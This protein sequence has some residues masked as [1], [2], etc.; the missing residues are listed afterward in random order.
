MQPVPESNLV[1]RTPA[2]GLS[3]TEVLAR[4]KQYGENSLP[5]EKSTPAWTILLNQV[6]SPLVY[7]ILVAAVVSLFAKEFS[8]F[9]I[10]MA[11]VVIDVI[12]G[13]IQEYQAQ[14]TYTAL[15]GLL[16]P[17]TTVFRDGERCEVEVW[18]LVPGDLVLLNAGE[19]V[20]G[21][22]VILEGIKLALD[23]AILTGESEAV[24]KTPDEQVYMGTTVL[25]GRGQMQINQTGPATELGKIATSLQEHVEEDTPLQKRLKSFSKT[26]T[27]IVA[28]FTLAIL[29]TG[30]IMGGGF[31]DM[32]RTSII[33]AIA[34]VPEGLLIAVTVILVLGM[35]KILKRNGLVKRLLAVET[36]GSVTVICTDK[37]GTLTEGRMRVSTSEILDQ[38]RALQTMVLCNDL[39]GPV[40][41]AMWEQAR[42]I[43]GDDPQKMVDGSQRLEEELFTSE[44]KYMI[45]AITGNIFKGESYNFLKGAPEIVLGMCNLSPEEEAR[46]RLKVDQW[47]GEGLR[48][49]G[50]AYRQLGKL[51]DYS[52]YSWVGLVGM[53][54]PVRKGVVESVEVAQKAGIQVKMITG[55]YLK[56]AEHIARSI[57]IMKEGEQSLEG[58]AVAA[59]SEK[60]LQEHVRNT[61]V[62]ARIRPQDKLRIIKALQ[63]NG[64]ITSMI[65]DG[66]NDAPALQRSNI[67]VVVGS[68]TDVAKETADVILLDNNFATIVAAIEEG[69]IIFQN[70]R[71]VVAYTLSNSFAEV[72]TI[73]IAMILGWPAPLIVAQILWIHLICDG[74]SDIVLGFEPKEPGIMDEKP[75]SLKEPILSHLGL[76]LIGIISVSS[77]TAVL[78]LFHHLYTAHG[79]AVEGRSIVFASFAVNSMVYIFAYRSMRQPL[80]RMNKL[81]VNMPLVWAVVTGLGMAILPFLIPG[82]RSLLGLVP[83]TLAE[84]MEVVGIALGL[85]A[86]VEVGKWISNK[87]HAND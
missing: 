27:W 39:E 1:Q 45:T 76:S 16:K 42:K 66:V 58:P 19:K 18:E 10:I 78:F 13:F 17:T 37:T 85:L 48:M 8:D 50:L 33:L 56:T 30:M 77:A 67:G 44:T 20:P 52:G 31:L 43:M 83:L 47:A 75:K 72:L 7:I 38:E 28:G 26:L 9:A 23:E 34:A 57:G 35:R 81:T 86:V 11:V 74:P 46:Y 22:G 36:L 51:D 5:I 29:A 54:D 15:K 71:K 82:L 70:I 53:E 21:D 62:F 59:L 24:N 14:K 69:R 63:E 55:D 49:I 3:K 2:A 73:F 12:L 6:K 41:I 40:D 79:N 68:A 64:E 84:W 32:L 80:F 4:R 65:G 61:S 25:T 60:E 87:V